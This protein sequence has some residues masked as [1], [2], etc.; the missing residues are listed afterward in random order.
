VQREAMAGY[1]LRLSETELARY[2][3]MARSA[4]EHE[5]NDWRAAGIRPG[6]RVADVGCGPALILIEL[7]RLVG[8][9]GAAVGVERDA[10]ARAVASEL[11]AAEGLEHAVVI[12]GDAGATGVEPA[13]F[14]AVMVRHVL[15]H[16]GGCEAGI[17]AHLATLLRPGGHLYR[18][19]ADMPAFR[20]DPDDPDLADLWARWLTLMRRRGNDPSI[21]IRLAS[22]LRAAGLD[23]VLRDARWYCQ[24]REVG[25]RLAPWAAREALVADGLATPTDI[26]RWDAAFDRFDTLPG[27]KVFFV[28]QFRAVGRAAG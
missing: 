5:A 24:P 2:R 19:E 14:D 7:A 16:N 11:L 6:A 18:I 20:F 15:I 12:E 1:T 23:V 3:M 26:A 25:V 28:P 22:L 17:V 8:P 9:H 4:L 21:G 10:E 13:S 27:E